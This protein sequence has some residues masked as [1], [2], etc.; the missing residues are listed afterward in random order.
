MVED[1]AVSDEVF[2][3]EVI[4]FKG[5]YGFLSWKKGEVSMKDM[6]VHWSNII[7]DGYKTL[8]KGQKV[9]FQMGVN[10]AGDP[11]AINVRVIVN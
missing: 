6:F 8:Q 9:S 10:F 5:S 11:K 4:F 2:Y 1:K 3:G 7:S